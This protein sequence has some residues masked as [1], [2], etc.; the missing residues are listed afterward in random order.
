MSITFWNALKATPALFGVS[1]LIASSAYAR[2]NTTEQTAVPT[3]ETAVQVDTQLAENT[4]VSQLTPLETRSTA[5]LPDN[6]PVSEVAQAEAAPLDTTSI[7]E[8]INHYSNGVNNDSLDQVT[9]VTQ[10][11]DVSPGDWAYEALR[12]LSRW[13]GKN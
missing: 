4:A 3:V 5:N 6:T 1:L 11:R 2:E 12:S 13:T 9:N 10:F 8:Q 7:L